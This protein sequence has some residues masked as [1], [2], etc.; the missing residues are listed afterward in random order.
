MA[1]PRTRTT[2][3]LCCALAL[4]TGTVEAEPGSRQQRA[5]DS[6]HAWL[7][8]NDDSSQRSEGGKGRENR[9]EQRARDG[10]RGQ[11]NR[12]GRYYRE[13]PE[14]RPTDV[15]QAQRIERREPDAVQQ[16]PEIGI[17]PRQRAERGPSGQ[18]VQ[19]R[20]WEDFSPEERQ[21]LERRE[22]SFRALPGE[23]QQ[24]LRQ[25]EQRYRSMPPDQRE[26][27]RRRWESMSES[28]RERYRHRIEKRD[29]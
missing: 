27:L 3:V 15:G 7:A 26:E 9:A 16:R 28:D 22:Q 6:G 8:R 4:A 2:I 20:R 1:E 17:A 24:R 14:R 25:A 18:P 21:R 29:D 12:T 23:Q 13:R 19:S 5:R 10:D 11:E